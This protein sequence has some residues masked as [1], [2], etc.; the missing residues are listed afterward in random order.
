MRLTLY[1]VDICRYDL[2]ACKDKHERTSLKRRSIRE[3]FGD[4]LGNIDIGEVIRIVKE[5]R[6]EKQG[7]KERERTKTKQSV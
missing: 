7:K 2:C 1:N 6:R 4:D 5:D 3:S